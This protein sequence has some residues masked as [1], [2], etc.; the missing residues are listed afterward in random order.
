MALIIVEKCEELCKKMVH[1]AHILFGVL[2]A[3]VS[4][5]SPVLSAI[6]TSVFVIY[7]LDQEWNLKDTAYEEIL[8]FLIGL[9]I[10]EIALIAL[11]KIV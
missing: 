5:I 8:E 10:G 11:E 6:N 3:L 7:E 1:I 4:D 9:A 2:T